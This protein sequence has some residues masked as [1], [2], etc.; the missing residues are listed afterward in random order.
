MGVH[1][2]LSILLYV[3]NFNVEKHR[4]LNNELNQMKELVYGQTVGRSL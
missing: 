3:L 4:A 1:C 2:L